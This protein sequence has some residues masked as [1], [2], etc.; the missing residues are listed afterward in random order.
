MIYV[1][2]PVFQGRGDSLI[3]GLG[4]KKRS[5]DSLEDFVVES[6]FE[7]D[8]D[9]GA[10]VN[11]RNAEAESSSSSSSSSERVKRSLDDLLDSEFSEDEV[12][13]RYKRQVGMY[14]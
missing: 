2:Y 13:A 9:G 7:D 14:L 3:P 1:L 8:G 12:A 6:I 10:E 11:K 5:L 4:R